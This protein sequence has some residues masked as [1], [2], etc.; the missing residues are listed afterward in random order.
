MTLAL[1]LDRASPVESF[2]DLS[3][4][5]YASNSDRSSPRD[6]GFDTSITLGEPKLAAVRA[7]RDA[8]IEA[9]DYGWDG[10]TAAPADP[11]AICYALQ[12]LSALSHE[13]PLPDI[14]VDPDGD[15]ALDWDLGE[16]RIFSVRIGRDGTLNYAGLVGHS[17]FHGMEILREGIPKAVSAGIDRVL[18]AREQRLGIE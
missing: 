1:I 2:L 10:Y 13:I 16:R 4:S 14:A 18:S 3:L 7:L 9:Q 6:R 8:V 5:R 12:F 15:I 11:G 17:S